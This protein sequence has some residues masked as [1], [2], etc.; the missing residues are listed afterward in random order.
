[1]AYPSY[2]RSPTS[3]VKK[4][5]QRSSSGKVEKGKK[6]QVQSTI[7]FRKKRKIDSGDVDAM[8]GSG[9]PRANVQRRFQ[10]YPVVVITDED[11][12][13]P[14]LMGPWK[15]QLPLRRS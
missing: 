2:G 11:I 10:A 13:Q 3:A 12:P 5:T 1:M 8:L 15:S 4:A 9:T 6:R 14:K 7:A